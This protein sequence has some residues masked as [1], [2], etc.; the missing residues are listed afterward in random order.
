M[1]RCLP[2]GGVTIR[3]VA[4]RDIKDWPVLGTFSLST[5]AGTLTGD[6]GGSVKAGTQTPDGFPFTFQLGVTGATG[7]LTGT[8]GSLRLEGFF[9]LGAATIHGTVAGTL[10]V[11]PATPDAG[12]IQ[13][14]SPP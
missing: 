14:G 5:D 4:K 1:V 2:P 6:L 10:M 9:G 11:P 12:V 7:D 8:T 3:L 13:P